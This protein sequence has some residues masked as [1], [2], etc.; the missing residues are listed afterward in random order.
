VGTGQDVLKDISSAFVNMGSTV[1]LMKQQLIDSPVNQTNV[2]GGGG[3]TQIV[4]VPQ[5]VPVAMVRTEY[6]PVEEQ[7]K[8][9]HMVISVFGK[10]ASR[11]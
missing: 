1:N 10:G 7:V 6:V 9:Q 3:G 8:D 5:V 11:V 4:P 2:G